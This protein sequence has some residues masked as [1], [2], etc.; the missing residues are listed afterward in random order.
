VPA[1]AGTGVKT[2]G[3]GPVDDEPLSHPL[4]TTAASNETIF[5]RCIMQAPGYFAALVRS[6]NRQYI[7]GLRDVL[8]ANRAKTFEYN[9]R[10]FFAL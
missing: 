10:A 5:N 2:I 8:G 6:P 4:R 7:P 3:A 1:G 9:A